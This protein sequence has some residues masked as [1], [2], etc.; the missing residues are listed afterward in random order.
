MPLFA[1]CKLFQERNPAFVLRAVHDTFIEERPIPKLRNEWDV[2]VRIEQT[3]ICGSDV[4][5][6]DHGRIGG[7]SLKRILS[8]DAGLTDDGI[9]QTSF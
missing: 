4:H 6:W 1:D 8:F 2:R 7:M 3:G 5:Y 9:K